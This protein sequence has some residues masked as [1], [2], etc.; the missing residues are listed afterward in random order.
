MPSTLPRTSS[1]SVNRWGADRIAPRDAAA[2]SFLVPWLSPIV[3]R[4]GIAGCLDNQ[5]I[6]DEPSPARPGGSL[7]M[8]RAA[9]RRSKS[10]V[11]LNAATSSSS[12]RHSLSVLYIPP[13]CDIAGLQEKGARW[14]TSPAQLGTRKSIHDQS[15]CEMLSPQPPQDVGPQVGP[16]LVGRLVDEP[17]DL[18]AGGHLLQ[19]AGLRHLHEQPLVGIDAGVLQVEH[20]HLGRL[21]RQPAPRALPIQQQ[22]LEP[23][24]AAGG[25][26]IQRLPA[27]QVQRFL[28]D[29][30][31]VVG[32]GHGVVH[33]AAGD[34]LG[35]QIE[36]RLLDLQRRP[37][38]A[39][40]GR[41]QRLL[42]RQVAADDRGR[43]DG[44]VE[45]ERRIGPACLAQRHDQLRRAGPQPVGDRL[46]GEVQIDD[47]QPGQAVA[48]VRLVAM[49][50]QRAALH[51]V[52]APHPLEPIGPLA[53]LEIA[54]RL[55]VGRTHHALTGV[56]D[57]GHQV[58]GQ[59]AGQMRLVV[60]Q[61]V[62]HAARGHD[63]QVLRRS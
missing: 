1:R 15:M 50:D 17:L 14:T 45:R 19:A 58:R 53:E 4:E 44:I 33:R 22:V 48:G 7:C 6:K 47:V 3:F 36:D 62:E 41:R 46:Q 27:Q 28:P 57:R 40:N 12:D 54:G 49:V 24:V 59:E 23:V 39:A 8:L 31:Q 30:E 2:D 5:A 10:A 29:A 16:R 63:V 43:V 25:Q 21:P 56:E 9:S 32:I 55:I 35:G 20:L 61:I 60:Q 11:V 18:A 51:G 42:Q 13:G 26:R 37:T 52:D 34:Q 38:S